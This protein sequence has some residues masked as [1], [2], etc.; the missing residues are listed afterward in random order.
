MNTATEILTQAHL[1]LMYWGKKIIAAEK[2]G[3]F[4]QSNIDEA[5]QWTTCACG[6]MLPSI[7]TEDGCRP[8][9]FKLQC[10]GEDFTNFVTYDAFEDAAETLVAIEERAMEL[11]PERLERERAKAVVN[12]P[13]NKQG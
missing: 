3:H 6:R 12:H 7:E 11:L 2:R 9:D 1:H 5:S 4:T 8:A 10:L 13:R